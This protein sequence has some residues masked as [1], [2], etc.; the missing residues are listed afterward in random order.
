MLDRGFHLGQ[1]LLGIGR[2]GAEDDLRVGVDVL[3]R[4]DQVDDAFLTRDAADKEDDRLAGSTPYFS[5]AV[6]L[7]VGWYWST[8]M[9]L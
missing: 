1:D 9:P 3:D 4:V 7:V 6:G 8:L 5:S 2:T